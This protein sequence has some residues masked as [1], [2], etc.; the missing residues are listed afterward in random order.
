MDPSNATS[1][2]YDGEKLETIAGYPALTRFIPNDGDASKPLIA[3]IPGLAH[4]ARIAY[5][6]HNGSCS[7]DFLAY[8]FHKHGFPFLGISYPI[9]SNPE[10]IPPTGSEFSLRDWGRQ[11]ALA[12]RKAVDEH[13]LSPKVVILAWSM[14]GKALMPVTSESRALGLTVS[15]YVSLAST[16]A[17]WGLRKHLPIAHVPLTPAGYWK[18]SLLHQRFISQLLEQNQLNDERIIIDEEVFKREY[19]G[20]TPI[21]SGCWGYRYDIQEKK[22]VDEKWTLLEDGR[23]DDYAHLPALA[24]LYPTSPL[25]W[26]HSIT[27]K[28]NWGYL[29]VQKY[30]ATAQ[31]AS[32]ELPTDVSTT[33]KWSLLQRERRLLDHLRTFIYEIPDR[34]VAGVEGN[35]FFFVGAMGARS[36][37]EMVVHFIKEAE[38]IHIALD[39]ILNKQE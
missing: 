27:D 29:M 22:L 38:N 31:K 26:Q 25:D 34:M 19:F 2:L 13:G 15:L 8:W 9:D 37:A 18:T 11:T 21:A 12:M 32:R 3:F 16:P 14:G 28:A 30:V 17:L 7:K 5:G 39:D 35:H 23:V 20:S 10:I 6:G 1:P 36:T 24:A 33:E 4:N